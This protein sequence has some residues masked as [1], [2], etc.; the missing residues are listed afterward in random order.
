MSPFAYKRKGFEHEREVRAVAA[1]ARIEETEDSFS[2]GVTN[3]EFMKPGENVSIDISKLIVSV[4]LAP[5]SSSSTE[6]F[7]APAIERSGLIV[8]LQRSK[9]D[10]EPV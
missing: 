10:D 1:K 9:L 4:H 2:M 6:D 8:P 5:G 3:E 7:V